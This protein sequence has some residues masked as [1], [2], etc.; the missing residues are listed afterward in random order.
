MK[1]AFEKLNGHL[2]KSSIIACEIYNPKDSRLII[3][4]LPFN[5]TLKHLKSLFEPFGNLVDVNLPLNDE[6]RKRGFAFIQFQTLDCAKK[7]VEAVNNTKVLNRTVAVDF[8]VGKVEYFKAI[9][10][11]DEVVEKNE[12]D[13]V[14]E[15]EDA[16][17]KES[18]DD[19][20]ISEE[21][22]NIT[23]VEEDSSVEDTFS[24]TENLKEEPADFIVIDEEED[25]E[26]ER[27]KEEQEDCTL[28]IRNLSFQTTEDTLHEC[29]SKFGPLDYAKITIDKLTLLSRGTAFVRFQK[30][31]DAQECLSKAAIPCINPSES[32][33]LI[34]QRVVSVDV[35][36]SRD[37]ATKL[38]Q[39]SKANAKLLDKRNTYLL[40]EGVLFPESEGGKLQP[41]LATK[42]LDV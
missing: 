6:G 23:D 10:D 42:S 12:L 28:F 14:N 18:D 38:T 17:Q 41:E 33:F 24:K 39:A 29:F 7:A 15:N 16:D 31:Q 13:N 32:P 2:F 9:G 19:N 27:S 1:F 37:T 5:A 22:N 11:K 4:N 40:R 26:D 21:N 8:A 36:V 3:R 25:A 35:A 34:D 30:L 20:A